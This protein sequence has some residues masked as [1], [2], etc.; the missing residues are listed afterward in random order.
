MKKFLDFILMLAVSVAL[1]LPCRGY[2]VMERGNSAIGGEI[3]VP[4]MVIIAYVIV[5][6]WLEEK[7]EE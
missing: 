5:T 6:D 2:A 4:V 1:Y 7:A 3:F